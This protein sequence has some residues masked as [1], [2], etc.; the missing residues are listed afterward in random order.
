MWDFFKKP[1]AK[2]K[3]SKTSLTLKKPSSS[4]TTAQLLP[5]PTPVSEVVEGNEDS[6]WSMWDDSVAFQDSP[7]SLEPLPTE[8][9]Q[10]NICNRLRRR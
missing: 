8:W 2:N 5:Q 10:W 9:E 3:T 1:I 7:F 4:R 6:H